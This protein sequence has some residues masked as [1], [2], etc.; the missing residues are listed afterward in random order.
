MGV[1]WNR[2]AG[3]PRSLRGGRAKRYK[4]RREAH[5]SVR[6]YA[7][8]W[9]DSTAAAVL[10]A[11]KASKELANAESLEKHT[12]S[13]LAHG[14]PMTRLGPIMKGRLTEAEKKEAGH[15]L[16]AHCNKLKDRER[17]SYDI[18]KALMKTLYKRGAQAKPQA[19][20]R[21]RI[22]V[23]YSTLDAMISRQPAQDRLRSIGDN[24][25]ILGGVERWPMDRL[26]HRGIICYE[27]ALGRM[28]TEHKEWKGK[29]TV[30][31]MTSL[32]HTKPL[33]TAIGSASDHYLVVSPGGG[34]RWASVQ[35]L[36]RSMEV[37]EGGVLWH[38]L[39]CPRISTIQMGEAIG[40][41]VHTGVAR[42]L[43][44]PLVQDGTLRPGMTY[45]SAYTGIDTFAA[46]VDA[47]MGG[48]WRYEFASEC[49]SSLRDAT[50]AIWGKR[51]LKSERC[52][53][54]AAGESAAGEARV[55]LWVATPEC[56]RF[57]KKNHRREQGEQDDGIREMIAAMSYVERRLPTVV[58]VE[59]VTEGTA[60]G[61]MMG[62]LRRVAK[63]AGYELAHDKVCPTE[64]GG[65]Q[66]RERAYWVLT[67]RQ[68][69]GE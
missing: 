26:Q 32:V 21:A 62:V 50:V 17:S 14:Q 55:D 23:Q 41:G 6:E 44:R 43:L 49:K 45:G 34:I 31:Y 46:A 35:E 65:L 63:A 58:I 66:R 59:N 36:A 60:V 18:Y 24:Q 47:E 54:D 12:I 28:T 27:R 8:R 38:G 40:R 48:N 61:P 1:V 19:L 11:L 13:L 39:S 20:H 37:P 3:A 64:D 9:T 10:Y 15:V 57:S 51:G 5:G 33:P 7:P 25:R 53:G 56:T 69:R 16:A 42:S 2:A 29:P 22:P 52:H 68:E 67:R 4:A 30:R